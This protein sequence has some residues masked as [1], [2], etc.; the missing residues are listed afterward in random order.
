MQKVLTGANRLPEARL[1]KQFE[2]HS[3]AIGNGLL[4]AKRGLKKQI[5]E[6]SKLQKSMLQ[7]SETSISLAYP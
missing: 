3:A 4:S 6:Y 1:L 5:K 2:V 7:N